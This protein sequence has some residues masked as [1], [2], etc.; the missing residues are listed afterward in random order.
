V[1]DRPGK[2]AR[3][4][5]IRRTAASCLSLLPFLFLPTNAG[6]QAGSKQSGEPAASTS[7]SDL[8]SRLGAAMKARESGDVEAIGKASSRVIALGLVEMAKL[9]VDQKA[10][11]EAARLCRES[12]EYEDSPETRIELAIVSLYAKK[13]GDAVEEA[14]AVTDK[15]P[16][17]ALA[18]SVRGEAL[19]EKESYEEAAKA[20]GTAVELKRD[21]EPL[22]ALG[23]AHLKLGDKEKAA[24]DFE[25]LLRLTGEHGWSRLLVGQAYQKA[26]LPEEAAAQFQKALQLNPRTPEANYYWA[27]TL[28]K[29]N[30]WNATPEVKAHLLDE[31]KVNPRY[32][33]AYYL[34]GYFASNERNYAESNRYLREAARL[35]ASLP[36]VWLY[37]GLNAQGLGTRGQAEAYFRKAIALTKKEEDPA[38]HLSIRK[39]YVGLGRILLA[40]GRKEESE[41]MFQK[42]RELEKEEQLEGQRRMAKMNEKEAAAREKGAE[43]YLPEGEGKD[44]IA[45][46]S[47]GKASGA[48]E[49]GKDSLLVPRGNPPDNPGARAEAYLRTVLGSSLNDLATAEAL[50]EKYQQAVAHYREAE[51]WSKDIP[52]QQRNLGLALF[53]AGS[54]AEA[55]PL[56]A[57]A[58][59]EEPGDE[60]AR[61]A[62]GLAYF[63]M[64][65]FAKCA[66]TISAI[67]GRAM[68]SP[69]LGLAWAASLTET[70]NKNEARTVVERLDSAEVKFGAP[71]MTRLGRLWLK[72]GEAGRAEKTFREAL[73]MDATS[74][75]ARVGLGAALLR[76]ARPSEAVEALK[77]VPAAPSGNWEVHYELGQAYLKLGNLDEAIGQLREAAALQPE[78]ISVHSELEA[79]YRRAGRTAEAQQEKALGETLKKKTKATGD[80]TSRNKPN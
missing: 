10:Y 80:S 22:Y 74:T 60:H 50:Q 5:G 52:G 7:N 65:E 73:Q 3:T 19:L 35:N 31:L 72:L 78:A 61:A 48:N 39:A 11:Q 58:V 23:V 20:L 32:F 40:S 27:L 17:N 66:Q 46:V 53:Y 29:A 26:N 25:E 43:P 57:R 33:L 18:W 70:G 9:R 34:L 37:L 44:S 1:K 67:S 24:G 76:L 55:V 12:L 15:D 71:E 4:M 41:K 63:D 2:P 21:T 54:S 38:K 45:A 69:Q 56:L 59:S 49:S 14:T 36:E 79:A 75:E 77:P 64:K 47:G 6:A 30:D 16:N 42:A 28:L 13:P 8:R 51:S 68:E 62:L